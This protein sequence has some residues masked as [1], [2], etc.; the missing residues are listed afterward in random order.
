MK[1]GSLKYIVGGSLVGLGLIFVITAI[2]MGGWNTVW[3]FREISIDFDGIHFFENNETVIKGDTVN[4]NTDNIKNLNIDVDYGELIIKKGDTQNIEI[5][6]KNIVQKRFKCSSEGDTIKIKYGGGFSFFT[7]KAD[8][9]IT[10]TIPE[11]ARF[12]FACI[13]NGAGRSEI[14][15]LSSEELKINN[16]AG[17]IV[18]SDIAA[19][20]KIYIDSGAG[21][22]KLDGT[23]C[24]LLEIHGGM[25]EIDVDSTICTEL[26]LEQGVGEFKYSGEING[27]ADIDSGTGSVKMKLYG[28]SSDYSFDVDSGIGNVKVNGNSP[29]NYDG[30][31]YKFKIDS[32]IGEV[33]IDFEDK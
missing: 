23:S 12:E 28:L 7:W 22:V 3:N 11:N 14:K 33:R 5:A 1:K 17:E 19:S 10:I 27:D 2:C 21:A 16:G 6:T 32:G 9:E 8:S 4:M 20:K 18:L 25:G 24:G 31:K 15:G 30:G 29:V 13:E 26:K